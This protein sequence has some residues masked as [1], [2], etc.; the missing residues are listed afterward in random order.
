MTAIQASINFLSWPRGHEEWETNLQLIRPQAEE[1]W[2]RVQAATAS[3]IIKPTR[4]FTF[5][6]LLEGDGASTVAAGF[7]H[8]LVRE[9]GLRLL[10]VET[11][12]RRP[13]LQE[14]DLAPRSPGLAGVLEKGSE[15]KHVIFDLVRAGFHVLPAGTPK[16][17][18]TSVLTAH[19]LRSF[20]KDLEPFF[21]IVIL[22]APPLTTAPECRHLVSVADATIPVF[23]SNRTAPE[24]AAYWLAKIQEFRG[25]I[26]AVCLNGVES[27]LPTRVRALL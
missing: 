7:A 1:I 21:D 23:R 12:L 4:V 19:A 9:T 17:S 6:G 15:L 10:L 5:A 16:S 2:S 11:D 22:D 24:Q 3:S 18:P 27:V 20:L 25:H 8:F 14:L 26:G 13:T